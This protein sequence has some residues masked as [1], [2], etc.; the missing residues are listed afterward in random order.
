LAAFFVGMNPGWQLEARSR[1]PP[2]REA[3]LVFDELKKAG[4]FLE[5]HIQVDEKDKQGSTG[6]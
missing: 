6:R 1:I 4:I 3:A 2:P 5:K